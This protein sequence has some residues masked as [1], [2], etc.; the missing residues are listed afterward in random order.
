MGDR[1]RV[2][3]AF[4]GWPGEAQ[5]LRHLVEVEGDEVVSLTLDVGQQQDLDGVREAALEA[6]A[7]RAHVMDVRDQ[8]ALEY[9]LPALRA[10]GAQ[11]GGVPL[12][13]E[14]RLAAIVKSLVD[15]AGM[16]NAA[17]LAH[18]GERDDASVHA[19]LEELAQTVRP[20]TGGF[21]WAASLLDGDGA[22]EEAVAARDAAPSVSIVGREQRLGVEPDGTAPGLYRATRERSAAP[23]TPATLEIAFDKGTPVSVNGVRLP[24]IELLDSL[25]TIVGVHGVGRFDGLVGPYS[26]AYDAPSRHVGEAPAVIVLAL[27]YDALERR[28]WPAELVDLKQQLAVA[29]RGLVRRGRW[30][31][32][33]RR[34]ISAFVADA[35]QG[36]TGTVRLELFK[37]ACRVKPDA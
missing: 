16:E 20:G 6:G 35:Q 8:L 23:E 24:F 14:L 19:H 30:F 4:A 25:D 21:V 33:T 9:L 13:R 27:A 7:V 37:G 31:S 26:A 10:C 1:T 32:S 3:F 28:M 2:A 12:A 18:G 22:A 34:A 5:A 36:L 15:V 17:F 11:Q 29:F